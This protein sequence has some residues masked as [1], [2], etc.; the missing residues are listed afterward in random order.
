MILYFNNNLK[1]RI[2]V[3][4]ILQALGLRK[5]QYY[6]S[7]Q[8][9][10]GFLKNGLQKLG[11]SLLDGTY[12]GTAL[13]LGIFSGYQCIKTI[14][15]HPF[16]SFRWGVAM[17]GWGVVATASTL[18]SLRKAEIA[19]QAFQ[20]WY[21]LSLEKGP[22]Y[23]FYIHIRPDERGR[24]SYNGGRSRE[25]SGGLGNLQC[26]FWHCDISHR[27]SHRDLC[28]ED[29]VSKKESSDT[30]KYLFCEKGE[31]REVA[32]LNCCLLNPD[33]ELDWLCSKP[34]ES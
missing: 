16:T 2:K 10:E 14:R 15:D 34:K 29:F 25:Y 27:L 20:D 31:C 11:A 12:A 6:A 4:G 3:A 9:S 5:N 1:L 22:K 7:G 23:L 18:V 21:N 19:Y 17:L 33:R 24:Y 26:N 32:D 13:S 28:T 30:Q 8:Y